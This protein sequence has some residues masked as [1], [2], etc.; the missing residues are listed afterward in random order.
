VDP[1]AAHLAEHSGITILTFS[2]IYELTDKVKKL[3]SE[4]EPKIETEEIVGISK[5]LKLFGI[6]KG[7]Q[8]IGGRVLSGLIKRGAVVKII[9]R[10]VEIGKGVVKE[11]QQSKIVTDSVSEGA[12]FGAMIESKIEVVPG[13]VLKAVV[14]VTK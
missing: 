7:K 9:R 11:L 5:V 3:L 12:E 8:V 2:I 14:L 1:Q 6:T 13:D 10:E 4:R